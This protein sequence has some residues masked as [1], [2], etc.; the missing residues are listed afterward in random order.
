MKTAVVSK[1]QIGQ[2][3][4]ITNVPGLHIIIGEG[5]DACDTPFGKKPK[6]WEIRSTNNGVSSVDWWPENELM[7]EGEFIGFLDI[8]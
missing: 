5:A 8:T 3:V 4:C 2:H 1:F 7:T 6:Y